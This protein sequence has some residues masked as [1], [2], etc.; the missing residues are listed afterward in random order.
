MTSRRTGR[1]RRPGP[2][3]IAAIILVIAG[4]L[5]VAWWIVRISA[6]DALVKRNPPAAA[7]VAPDHPRVKLALASLEFQLRNGALSPAGKKAANSALA[8]APLSEEPFMLA[9]VAALAAGREADGQRL[10]TESRRRD[11]RQRI[12]RLI[13]LDRYLRHSRVGDSVVEIAVLRRLIPEASGILIPELARM[14]REPRTR[15][16]LIR[17]LERDPEM[18]QAVLAHLANTAADPDLIL[19]IAGGKGAARAAPEGLPWQRLLLLKLIEKGDVARAYALWRSFAGLPATRD[20]KGL[21]DADFRG[22]PG[23]PPFNWSFPETPAGVAERSAGG[24]QVEFYGRET[25]ELAGQVLMLAPGRYRL[26]F[27]A[28]GAAGGESSRIGWKLQCLG[29]AAELGEIALRR[30]DYSPRSVTGDFVVP[31]QGCPAQRL[32]LVGTAAEFTKPQSATIRNIK[33]AA[34]R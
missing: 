6:V 10:L 24:L 1:G 2:G 14:A 13:L 18:Q 26:G 28:E 20:A 31:A 5:F 7:L 23:A 3:R 33:L 32:R 12:S 27:I 9:G 17:V 25:A 21:Y 4:S 15:E 8:Q 29:N 19:R 16:A 34:V 30:I 22:L 11:P